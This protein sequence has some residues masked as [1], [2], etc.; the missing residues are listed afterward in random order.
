MVESRQLTTN[1]RTREHPGVDPCLALS[2]PAHT[3][4]KYFAYTRETQGESENKEWPTTCS[5]RP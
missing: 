5:R 4:E 2:S 3:P 1:L